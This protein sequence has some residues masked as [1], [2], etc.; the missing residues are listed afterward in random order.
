[1]SWIVVKSGNYRYLS[2][3]GVFVPWT[4]FQSDAIRFATR[5]EAKR[6]SEESAEC[7]LED[8]RVVK[9]VPRRRKAEGW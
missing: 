8:C 4:P 3:D 2:R 9:L 1:M 6:A 7:E 5:Q